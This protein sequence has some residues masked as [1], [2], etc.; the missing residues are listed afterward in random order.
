MGDPD[1]QPKFYS[2]EVMTYFVAGGVAGAT[3]RT[4]VSPLERLKII[5]QVQPRAS[6]KQYKGVWS[7]LVRMWKEE[8]FKGYMRGNGVNCLRIVPY[9]AVQFTTYEQV[10][11]FFIRDGTSQ[12][13]TPKRLVSGALA[14]IASVCTTYPLDLVRARLSI[15][16]ASIPMRN[17]PP[18]AV[19]PHRVPS[20]APL[21]P[22]VPYSR[23]SHRPKYSKRDLSIIGMT[24]KIM[25]EEGGIRALYRGLIPTAL[26]VAPY[27]GINFA[28]YEWFRGIITPPGKDTI[29]RKL[30]CGALS[31][32][33]S[34][35]LTYPLDVLRRKMQVIGMKSAERLGDKRNGAVDALT[36]IIRTEGFRGLYRGLWPNLLKVA[37]SIATSFFT[38]ELVKEHLIIPRG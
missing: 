21:N 6:E 22:S 27:V 20:N 1:R 17:V 26:G 14:G 7:S 35:T 29:G 34:Q 15:A 36:S 30:L 2:P 8:G 24:T 4:V 13:D 10:K 25:R 16:T 12:L 31:G 23:S 33:I 3:S 38:Y 28:A 18:P 11:K 9:S 5:Q 19:Q 32:A 37:P